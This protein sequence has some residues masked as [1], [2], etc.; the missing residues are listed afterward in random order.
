LTAGTLTEDS[1]LDAQR[2]NYLVAIVRAARL[3][4]GRG[5]CLHSPPGYLDRRNSR[6]GVRRL[7]LNA[8]IAR[9]RAGEII[10][11]DALYSDVDI[12]SYCASCVTPLT[13]RRVRWRNR[14]A[15]AASY[16]AVA[17]TESFVCSRGSS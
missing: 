8:R 4:A 11:S 1:L 15:A 17:T 3:R 7:A 13:A 9:I 10:V 5:A 12:A 2:N 16:F 6:D 14:R